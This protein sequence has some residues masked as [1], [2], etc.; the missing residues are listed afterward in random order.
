MLSGEWLGPYQASSMRSPPMSR[1]TAVLERLLGRRPGGV[2]PQQEP[3]R[4][5]VP[6]T[7]HVPVEE[8]GCPGVVDV[9]V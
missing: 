4:L 2:V 8:G 9:M 1:A 7:N 5:L 6:D 3:P